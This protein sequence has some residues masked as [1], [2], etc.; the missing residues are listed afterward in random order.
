M[1]RFEKINIETQ[2][3]DKFKNEEICK[4]VINDLEKIIGIKFNLDLPNG[5]K[6]TY[7]N[8]IVTVLMVPSYFQYKEPLLELLQYYNINERGLL[9]HLLGVINQIKIGIS[10]EQMY[11][12]RFQFLN[13]FMRLP[14]FKSIMADD[15]FMEFDTKYGHIQVFSYDKIVKNKEVY[16]IIKT[17]SLAQKCH[18]VVERFKGYYKDHYIVTSEIPFFFGG[19]MYHSYFETKDGIIDLTNNTFYPDECFNKIFEPKELLKIKS[20]EFDSEYAKFIKQE[21]VIDDGS[22]APVLAMALNNKRKLM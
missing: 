2:V 14:Y 8:V 15:R 12:K 6:L 21:S 4:M 1:K 19:N 3:N 16:K 9:L 11:F 5:D 13:S 7:M 10:D 20:S 17:T 22:F 18:G